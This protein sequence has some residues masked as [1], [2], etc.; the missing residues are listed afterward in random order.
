MQSAP[1]LEAHN[2]L[3]CHVLHAQL[4]EDGGGYLFIFWFRKTEEKNQ[5]KLS[6]FSF[7]SPRN[8]Y[9]CIRVPFSH[10]LEKFERISRL[11]MTHCFSSSALTNCRHLFIF[12]GIRILFLLSHSFRGSHIKGEQNDLK[13]SASEM[14]SLNPACSFVPQAYSC[15]ELSGPAH[16]ELESHG[17]V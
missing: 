13:M 9:M 14:Q 6:D 10:S 3:P 12:W 11:F 17:S 2:T 4:K 1:G 15:S 5:S 7:F 8:I 16:S